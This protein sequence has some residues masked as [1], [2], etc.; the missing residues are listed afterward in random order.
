MLVT[1]TGLRFIWLAEK[2]F[3]M[4]RFLCVRK[5][6]HYSLLQTKVCWHTILQC[7]LYLPRWKVQPLIIQVIIWCSISGM[8]CTY[9]RYGVYMWERW[10]VHSHSDCSPWQLKA[11]R[12][13]QSAGCF[14]RSIYFL[15]IQFHLCKQE[16]K[17]VW[18]SVP[19]SVSLT[20]STFAWGCFHL[21]SDIPRRK[22]KVKFTCPRH[23]SLSVV[24]TIIPYYICIHISY[25]HVLFRTWLSSVV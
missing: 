25:I 23:A 6:Y 13:V 2:D 21:P 19:I 3:L 5:G 17:V 16:G 15:T 9:C 24:T 4:Q 11:A 20:H 1:S 18:L 22:K 12:A 8:V 14:F 10:V 7:I